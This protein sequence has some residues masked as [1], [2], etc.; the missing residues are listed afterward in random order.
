[1][2]RT[3]LHDKA[4]SILRGMEGSIGERDGEAVLSKGEIMMFGKTLVDEG[5]CS[6]RINHCIDGEG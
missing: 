4:S 1:M 3:G 5:N 2:V 6:S